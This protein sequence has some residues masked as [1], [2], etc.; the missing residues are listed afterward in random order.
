MADLAE[1]VFNTYKTDWY[2]IIEEGQSL[3][4]GPWNKDEFHSQLDWNP[5]TKRN[6]LPT[7]YKSLIKRRVNITPSGEKV[8]SHYPEITF[9]NRKAPTLLRIKYLDHPLVYD[10]KLGFGWNND[11]GKFEKMIRTDG[12]NTAVSTVLR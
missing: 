11:V 3:S 6:P 10:Q 5:A 2:E 4:V 9:S 7:W 8:I 12:A 1:Q